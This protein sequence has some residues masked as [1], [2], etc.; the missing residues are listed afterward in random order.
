[1][2]FPHIDVSLLDGSN[3]KITLI[4]TIKSFISFLD[5]ALPKSATSST[6][7]VIQ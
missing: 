7:P 1:L 2:I 3:E 6:M 5:N 4:L